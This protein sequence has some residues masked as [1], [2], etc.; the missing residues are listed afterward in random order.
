MVCDSEV[1]VR[2][3]RLQ[4]HL[5]GTKFFKRHGDAYGGFMAVDEEIVER[6]TWR[7]CLSGVGFKSKWRS[8]S[9]NNRSPLRFLSVRLLE[10]CSWIGWGF[11]I[12]NL[13]KGEIVF[14][15]GLGY[16]LVLG[17]LVSR[18]STGGSPVFEGGFRGL[19]FVRVIDICCFLF[20]FACHMESFVYYLSTLLCHFPNT[21]YILLI[22]LF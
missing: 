22:Y 11:F 21:F 8:L 3:L 14:G 20:F 4:V 9:K 12:A 10:L 16:F 19:V 5:W 2:V 7:W 15:L 18:G 13:L 17:V 1:W 6:L